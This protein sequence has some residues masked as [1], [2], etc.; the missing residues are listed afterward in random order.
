MRSFIPLDCWIA[1]RLLAEDD[2]KA[3]PQD[4]L[5]HQQLSDHIF[6]LEIGEPAACLTPV[7][8]FCS[9]LHEMEKRSAPKSLQ[10]RLMSHFIGVVQLYCGQE[11]VHLLPECWSLLLSCC[12]HI[13]IKHD[14]CLTNVSEFIQACVYHMCYERKYERRLREMMRWELDGTE[15]SSFWTELAAHSVAHVCYHYLLSGE[16]VHYLFSIMLEEAGVDMAHQF[17]ADGNT[18]EQK[19]ER[20]IQEGK[21]WRIRSP[22]CR[23][24]TWQYLLLTFAAEEGMR[25]LVGSSHKIHQQLM[26]HTTLEH[27]LVDVVAEYLNLQPCTKRKKRGREED[28]SSKEESEEN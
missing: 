14:I 4:D 24:L 15:L 8:W 9:F 13:H 11:E 25:L 7:R 16:R 21:Q 19:W 17:I 5:A 20:I 23:G 27:Q 18:L 10:D 6:L 2:A 3:F 22:A 26:D 1:D 28:D 12:T